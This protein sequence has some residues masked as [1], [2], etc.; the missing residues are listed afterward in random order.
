MRVLILAGTAEARRLATVLAAQRPELAVVCSLAGRVRAPV[1]P[2]GA[3]RVGGF[4]GPRGLAH[5]LRAQRVKA[6]IDA[7]HPFA[8][9]ITAA[10]VAAS[11]E[12]GVPLLVLRRPGWTR[13]PGDDWHWVATMAE[14]AQVLPALG[15][16]VFLTIGRGGLA[17][18][19]HLDTLWFL[20]RSV[21][22]PQPPTPKKMH[23]LL[24]R[25]PFMA[26]GERALL[27]EHRI[28]VLVTKN[29]GGEM[30]QAKLLAARELGIPVVIQ[31]RP[32]LPAG[33]EVEPTVPG[34]LCW[35]ERTLASATA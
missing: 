17:E 8:E 1:L 23:I 16:R 15:R 28:D 19:A 21:D 30:T 32:E 12:V 31:S 26:A 33:V 2:A 10:A 24:E 25:G 35:L 18:F 13:Q 11:R 4:G 3:V 14:G 6:V 9:R 7:T 34:A 22:P 20:V 27:R 29:S 5:Y